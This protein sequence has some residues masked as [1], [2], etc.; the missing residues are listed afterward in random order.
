MQLAPDQ[1]VAALSLA[2]AHD[3]RASQIED[4]VIAL[5]QKVRA[6]H[7]EI[8]FL[9]IKPQTDRTCRAMRKSRYGAGE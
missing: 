3:L 5:E 9:F 6:A 1:I 8:V 4:Q 7:P 2:F